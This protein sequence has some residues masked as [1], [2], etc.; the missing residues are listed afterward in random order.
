MCPPRARVRRVQ[1]SG[2]V[3]TMKSSSR[4]ATLGEQILSQAGQGSGRD[5][6]FVAR[7]DQ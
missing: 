4:G 5:A 7:K 3:P 1:S 6:S 2:L